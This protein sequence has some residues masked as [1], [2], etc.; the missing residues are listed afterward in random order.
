MTASSF[1]VPRRPAPPEQLI[2]GGQ[3][4]ELEQLG[5]FDHAL[6]LLDRKRAR[7]VEEGLRDARDGD[8]VADRHVRRIEP[9]RPVERDPF[10]RV[11]AAR[12]GD[13]DLPAAG[14]TQIHQRRRVL[15]AQNCARPA[16][17]H[18]CRPPPIARE[19]RVPD[20]VDALVE[21]LQPTELRPAVDRGGAHVERPEL[22]VRDDPVLPSGEVGDPL[23]QWALQVPCGGH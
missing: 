22:P 5:L 13:M 9:P 7:Q 23:C 10:V 15:M 16:C 2:D 3:V 12:S 18:R 21:P 11:P 4:E 20:G 17:E 8:A 6:E 1:P 14:A 19:R